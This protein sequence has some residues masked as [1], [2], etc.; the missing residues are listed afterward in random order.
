MH[1][2]AQRAHC[3]NNLKQIGLAVHNYAGTY[4][5][6][7]SATVAEPS[8]APERR[9]SWLVEMLP[10]MEAGPRPPYDKTKPWDAEENRP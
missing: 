6:F 9:L 7:P 1:E 4:V 5:R 3:T 8:L 2:T 10:Y